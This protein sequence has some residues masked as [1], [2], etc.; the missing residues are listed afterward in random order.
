MKSVLFEIDS[1]SNFGEPVFRIVT[2]IETGSYHVDSSTTVA[3]NYSSNVV[4]FNEA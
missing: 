3:L 4:S 1:E 2:L